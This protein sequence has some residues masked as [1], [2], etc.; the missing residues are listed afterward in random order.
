[1]AGINVDPQVEL[2]VEQYEIDFNLTAN[3]IL[4]DVD[5]VRN[6]IEEALD[7]SYYQH[8]NEEIQDLKMQ[9]D[10]FDAQV[11]DYQALLKAVV[12]TAAAIEKEEVGEYHGR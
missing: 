9:I 3:R 2:I 5:R 6:L 4:P 11:K 8:L 1:M 12:E 10:A 7:L